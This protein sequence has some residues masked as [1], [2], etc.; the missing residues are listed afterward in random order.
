MDIWELYPQL[1]S[2]ETQ[3]VGACAHLDNQP[4]QNLDTHLMLETPRDGVISYQSTPTDLGGCAFFKLDPVNAN[5]GET[6]PYQVC[7][8]NKYGENFC[9]RDSYLIWGNP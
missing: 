4:Q 9:E 8:T 3:E 7:F 5:N 2:S 6:I 1:S